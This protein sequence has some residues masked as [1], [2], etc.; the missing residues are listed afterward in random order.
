VEGGEDDDFFQDGDSDLD[1]DFSDLVMPGAVYILYR[2]LVKNYA[3][4]ALT[5]VSDRLPAFAGIAKLFCEATNDTYLAGLWRSRLLESLNWRVYEPRTK[6][7]LLPYRAPSWSWASIDGP[8]R[9][10]LATY[11]SQYL[12]Q[13]VDVKVQPRG[14]DPAG[15]V[16]DGFLTSHVRLEKAL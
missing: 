13:V 3:Q 7:D 8:F 14:E 9:P 11:S 12:I 2:D 4:C 1:T 6:D 10:E 16:V 15:A 5:K